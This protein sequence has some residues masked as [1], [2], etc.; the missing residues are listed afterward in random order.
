MTPRQGPNRQRGSA[1]LLVALILMMAMTLAILSVGRTHVTETRMAGN[2]Q[3]QAR[4]STV[5]E[6]EW[7]KATTVLTDSPGQL[8]WNR[9]LEGKVLTS[10]LWPA[11]TADGVTTTVVYQRTDEGSPLI[12]IQATAS[13]A[14]GVGISG[15]NSQTV[16][17]LTVLSPLAETAPPLVVNGCLMGS[18]NIAIRPINSDTDA[19]GDAL[20]YFADAPCPAFT[21]IDLHGGRF[22]RKP[23]E[24]S[25]WST[26]F[27]VNRDDYARLAALDLA[28]P[29]GQRRY[30]Y[31][32]S[33][34]LTVGKWNRS[35]G[36]ADKPVVVYFPQATGCPRFTA[37]VRIFGVVF[38]D[39]A[40]P[41][42]LASMTLEVVGNLVINGATNAGHATT[43]L[44]HIQTADKRQTRLSLPAIKVVKIP[45]TWKDF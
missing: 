34:D 12:D 41:Q 15:R 40:C 25:L 22:A 43:Q 28:L 29:P 31:I 32:E 14:G 9:P 5:A 42:P 20:W 6:S 7:E 26:F 19:A 27:S 18:V 37:G 44:S 3:L 16:R 38:I 10:Q 35:L 33:S 17:L 11:K 1:S 23:L 45:G 4:L 2:E 24:R 21:A 30:W 36:S 8:A 39:T 13:Q